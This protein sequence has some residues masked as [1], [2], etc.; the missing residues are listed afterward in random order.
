[1]RVLLRALALLALTL[2]APLAAED[3][4]LP[5]SPWLA[6][7]FEQGGKQVPLVNTDLLRSEVTLKR[8]PFT[9]L[10][11]VR[12]DDDAY[13]L[14]AWTDDSIF[15]A[16]DPTAR[17]KPTPPADPPI[18]FGRYTAMA[19]TAA[20]SGTLMLR[21]DGHH[22]LSGIRLGP[23]RC[24]HSLTFSTLGGKDAAGQWQEVPMRAVK[25]PL[26][27]VAWFDAD[28]DGVMRHGEYEFLVLNFR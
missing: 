16:A 18:Y 26:Y 14:T 6:F 7:R 20:G 5:H 11:P 24:R 15:A 3:T 9:I 4:P 25:G 22:Y 2:A 17:A 12:G 8:A 28:G 13:L 21:D 23:D 1:M 10:L 27:L 19:D